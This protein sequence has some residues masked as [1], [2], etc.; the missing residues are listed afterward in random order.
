M[1]RLMGVFFFIVI[2]VSVVF[3]MNPWIIGIPL[4]LLLLVAYTVGGFHVRCPECG[5]AIKI[6]YTKCRVCSWSAKNP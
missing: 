3:H 1:I 6:G 2:G 5:S 4:A